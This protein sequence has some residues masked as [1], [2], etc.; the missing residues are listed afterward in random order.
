MA[1]WIYQQC[2]LL[3]LACAMVVGAR[4]THYEPVLGGINCQEPCDLTAYMEPVNYGVTAACGPDIPYGTMVYMDGVGW[5]KCADHGGAITNERVDVAIPVSECQWVY[6]YSEEGRQVRTTPDDPR[7]KKW[8]NHWIMG[9]RNTVWL[10]PEAFSAIFL[11]PVNESVYRL[12]AE[13]WETTVLDH[14]IHP[15]P[16]VCSGFNCLEPYANEHERNRQEDRQNVADIPPH[17]LR[18]Q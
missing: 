6:Y 18:W 13:Q 3:G 5:R 9:Y 16:S 8:C 2:L 17:Q 10:S 4:I 7:A 12:T 11:A 14:N 1:S 15:L